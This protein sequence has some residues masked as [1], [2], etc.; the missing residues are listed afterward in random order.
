MKFHMCTVLG[1]IYN[2]Q[3]D[4]LD[5]KPAERTTNWPRVLSQYFFNVHKMTEGDQY[6]GCGKWIPFPIKVNLSTIPGRANFI[7]PKTAREICQTSHR[8]SHRLCFFY[9]K[10]TVAQL[11]GLFAFDKCCLQSLLLQSRTLWVLTAST[12]SLDPS[13]LTPEQTFYALG[14]DFCPPVWSEMCF[15][16]PRTEGRE[17]VLLCLGEQFLFLF[18]SIFLPSCSAPVITDSQASGGRESLL[19]VAQ[20]ASRLAYPSFVTVI[21]ECSGLTG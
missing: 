4:F 12:L 9:G 17:G 10:N 19:S 18:S 20:T 11:L 1:F 7:F 15:I 21:S 5:H 13:H 6:T 14:K 2:H 16:I 8:L 3:K